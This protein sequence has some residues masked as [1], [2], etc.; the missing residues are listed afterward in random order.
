MRV[1]IHLDEKTKELAS[2]LKEKLGISSLSALIRYLV[3]KEA[4]ELSIK[5]S[6]EDYE[7]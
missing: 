6:K 4:K 7:F 5:E 3:T 2:H 1:N